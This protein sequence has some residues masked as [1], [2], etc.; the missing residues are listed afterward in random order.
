MS[1][2]AGFKTR[3]AW[4]QSRHDFC[5]TN[6]LR[7]YLRPWHKFLTGIDVPKEKD[8]WTRDR[9]MR[10]NLPNDIDS[11][12]LLPK[13]PYHFFNPPPSPLTPFFRRLESPPVCSPLPTTAAQRSGTVPGLQ[14]GDIKSQNQRELWR[15]PLLALCPHT[16]LR[17]RTGQTGSG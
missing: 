2:R 3:W 1:V 17:M 5:L 10:P 16:G 14:A 7:A 15:S 4:F 6:S 12:F 13:T 8:R 9:K 11:G